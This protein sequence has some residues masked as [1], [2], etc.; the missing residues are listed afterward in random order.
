[1]CSKFSDS[2]YLLDYNATTVFYNISAT[3]TITSYTHYIDTIV[4]NTSIS[5][6]QVPTSSVLSFDLAIPQIPN[7]N[8]LPGPN[9]TRKELNGTQTMTDGSVVYAYMSIGQVTS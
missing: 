9:K 8:D 5:T 3:T 2:H 7:Y 6:T 1:M 4:T